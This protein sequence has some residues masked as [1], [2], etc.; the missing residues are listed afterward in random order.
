MRIHKTKHFKGKLL[1]KYSVLSRAVDDYLFAIDCRGHS[2]TMY[3]PCILIF[4][5]RIFLRRTFLKTST[6]G[7][8]YVVQM[9]N[10]SET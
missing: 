5:M 4:C 7:I 9:V 10:F 3:T 1:C 6:F 2:F 8:I